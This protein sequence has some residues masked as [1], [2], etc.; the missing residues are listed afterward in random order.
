[1]SEKAVQNAVFHWLV[2]H[3]HL[4]IRINSGAMVFAGEQSGGQVRRFV[5]FATWQVV[6]Q[7][8]TWAGVSDILACCYG[9][10]TAIE[11]KAPDKKDN[12]SEAQQ[13]FLAAVQRC[14]GLAIVADCIEDVERAIGPVK[15]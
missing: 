3:Q 10:F 6:G 12:L 4:A 7:A 15:E 14:G 13:I 8:L 5:R 2:M 1:M 11:I 9:R